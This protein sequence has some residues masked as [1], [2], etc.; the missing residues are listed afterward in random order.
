MKND[1]DQKRPPV[2]HLQWANILQRYHWGFL[3][4]PKVENKDKMSGT[5]YHVRN[6]PVEGWKYEEVP[7]QN[8]RST[9]NLLARILVAK[10]EDEERLAKI[11]RSIPIIQNDPSWRC[12]TW[13][14]NALAEIAKDGKAVGS[15]E[16][17]W[18]K[19]EATARD[20]VG[21]KAA[22]GRYQDAANLTKPSPTWDMLENKEVMP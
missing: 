2:L 13:V 14:A 19:V 5:R 20:Y 21:R 3:V 17:D 1:G 9:T 10:I 15:S 16:L 4:G 8:V 18:Q 11:F 6:R 7:L 22:A 12:R